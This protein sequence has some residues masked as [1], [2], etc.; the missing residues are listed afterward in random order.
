MRIAIKL[1]RATP[2]RDHVVRLA[3]S[4]GSWGDY[5]FAELVRRGGAA[6]EALKDPVFFR[7]LRIEAGALAWPNGFELDGG[8]LRRTL[9]ERGKLTVPNRG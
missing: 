2:L 1:L 9:A 8:A 3:F 4:D 5:D 7:R 6:A